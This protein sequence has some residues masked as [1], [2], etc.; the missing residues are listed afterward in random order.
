[1]EYEE[2]TDISELKTELTWDKY[3][4]YLKEAID[5]SSFMKRSE[6]KPMQTTKHDLEAH[7]NSRASHVRAAADI[8][9]RI[10]E[11]LGLNHKFIYAAMLMHDAG[12][13]FS[14]HDGEEIF[15][16]IGEEYNVEYY[17]HNAK[18]VEVVIGESICQKAISKIPN[19][20]NR[21]DL[22]KKLEEEFY[23]FLDVIIS[24]DGE[25]GV[26]EMSAKPKEYS[27]IEAA[28]FSKLREANSK[29][30]YKFVAQTIEGRIAKY[31]DVIAYLS[32]DIQDRFRL[33]IQ[34]K[35]DDDYL[36]FIGEILSKDFVRTREEKIE[37]ANYIIE[38]IKEEKLMQLV[39]D[40][41][42]IEN[43]EIIEFVG[44]IVDE[45]NKTEGYEEASLEKQ[46]EIAETIMEE[47][48]KKYKAEHIVD[49]MSNEE[50]KFLSADIE[51]IREF[52]RKKLR[53]RS[54]VV[55]A[56]TSK[57]R[58]TLIN[59]LLEE[60]ALQKEMTFSPQMTKM[61]FRAKELNYRYVPYTKWDYQRE[62]LPVATH[63]LVHMLALDLRK[64]GAIQDKFYD[65][66]MRKHIKDPKA[67]EYLSTLGYIEDEEQE[68]YKIKRG[69]RSVRHGKSKFTASSRT[70]QIAMAEL[71][72]SVYHYVLDS[73]ELFAISYE[74]TFNA[75]EHQIVSK[76]KNALGRLPEQDAKKRCTHVGFLDKKVGQQE[77]YIRKKL[78]EKYGDLDSITD[79]QILEFAE[80]IIE[81]HRRKMEGKMATQMA[82]NYIAG[83]TDK[84]IF[85]HLIDIGLF[86][87]E[88]LK[89]STR[90][91]TEEEQAEFRT[92]YDTK[93]TEEAHG[94]EER[95]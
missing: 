32:S 74:N 29:N 54:S 86:S 20:E 27:S 61:F 45:I 48:V 79:E 15:N 21:P 12:H 35:F 62:A 38:N 44:E 50:K 26:K 13:P 1:M 82:I 84:A 63:K 85:T 41:K 80:P 52:T 36:E 92:R 58:E 24:H 28:V 30:N 53:I 7:I 9:E 69:I 76:I 94:D 90:G 42:A 17:H 83:M 60:S 18:G 5:E 11:S 23:Y 34:K 57:I 19:I 37:I 3:I 88:Q 10:A 75:V 72:N 95:V 6:Y 87:E 8:A 46:E 64:S 47:Y 67:L 59:D 91:A 77:E 55:E 56:V 70:K 78:S 71:S 93:V 66:A 14:A 39:S 33:G 89:N 43:R 31:A 25:A 2:I 81:S 65:V 51:K 40:A 16:G 4:G 73:G 22:R 49:G 68:E